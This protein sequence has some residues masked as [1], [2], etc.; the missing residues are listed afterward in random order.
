MSKIYQVYHNTISA[1]DLS[2]QI[3]FRD[4]AKYLSQGGYEL[5]SKM[6]EEHE[7]NLENDEDLEAPEYDVD[8]VVKEVEGLTSY[9]IRFNASYIIRY[10]ATCFT[11]FNEFF[12]HLKNVE[13]DEHLV[14]NAVPD[15]IYDRLMYIQGQEDYEDED[16]DFLD[17][18]EVLNTV[19]EIEL[20]EDF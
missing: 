12:L 4:I 18:Q 6:V 16:P 14:D 1:V 10:N 2:E 8:I 11:R 7:E 13:Q 3:E 17:R 5:L 19:P 9:F 15:W 20:P